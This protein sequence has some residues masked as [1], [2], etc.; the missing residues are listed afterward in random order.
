MKKFLAIICLVAVT[1]LFI[2]ADVIGPAPAKIENNIAPAI[3]KSAKK[4]E[5][6]RYKCKYRTYSSCK[7]RQATA[8]KGTCNKYKATTEESNLV[9]P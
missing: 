2:S 5:T 6:K 8:W 4:L 7:Y 9:T 3:V 1:G